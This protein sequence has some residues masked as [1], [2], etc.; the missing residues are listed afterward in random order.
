MPDETDLTTIEGRLGDISKENQVWINEHDPKIPEGVGPDLAKEG[1]L[2][3][4]SVVN[5]RYQDQAGNA[6][7][8]DV[9]FWP[10]YFEGLL[11]AT[12]ETLEN[13]DLVRLVI[14]D[15][16]KFCQ[17]S[18]RAPK[19][20]IAFVM[21]QEQ[22]SREMEAVRTKQTKG[23]AP[24]FGTPR[25]RSVPPTAVQ[26]AALK[27]FPAAAR[28]DAIIIRLPE[29]E[30]RLTEIRSAVNTAEVPLDEKVLVGRV[31]EWLA[32]GRDPADPGLNY[33]DNLYL[34]RNPGLVRIG[35]SEPFRRYAAELDRAVAMIRIFRGN[36]GQINFEA[37][38]LAENREGVGGANYTYVSVGQADG[39]WSEP[40]MGKLSR[41]AGMGFEDTNSE[42]VLN[43][44]WDWVRGKGLLLMIGDENKTPSTGASYHFEF[45]V[46]G[47]EVYL[48][49]RLV[50]NPEDKTA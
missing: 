44:R 26:A 2:Q 29:D 18:G 14:Y 4:D 46:Q 23:E 43:Q 5:F 11:N 41:T 7:T 22:H 6:A 27:P 39:Q 10:Y 16:A 36:Q 30:T 32:I 17:E 49:P 45:K 8:R 19:G 24:P 42:S 40:A 12:T 20:K 21:T 13:G 25:Q 48:T 47:D 33:L 38:N 3:K 50:T 37:T 28:Q 31:G 35:V 9:Y 1:F 34:D 15:D